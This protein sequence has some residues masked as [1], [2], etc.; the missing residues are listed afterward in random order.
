MSRGHA[1]RQHP[2]LLCQIHDGSSP[3]LHPDSISDPPPTRASKTPQHR[4]TS[5]SCSCVALLHTRL[6]ATRRH[7]FADSCGS[8]PATEPQHG[9][10]FCAST[11]QA[12]R[13][14]N[15]PASPTQAGAKPLSARRSTPLI[16]GQSRSTLPGSTARPPAQ[17]RRTLP[18]ATQPASASLRTPHHA[19]NPAGA[20]ENFFLKALTNNWPGKRGR[21]TPSEL[22]RADAPLTSKLGWFAGISHTHSAQP[23]AARRAP[24]A[25]AGAPMSVPDSCLPKSSGR[26]HKLR[27]SSPAAPVAA[28]LHTLFAAPGARFSINIGCSS[29]YTAATPHQKCPLLAAGFL[30]PVLTPERHGTGRTRLV[31]SR[32][33]PPKRSL[34]FKPPVPRLDFTLVIRSIVTC[35]FLQ[36][37]I[38]TIFRMQTWPAHTNSQLR[39]LHDV[40]EQPCAVSRQLHPQRFCLTQPSVLNRAA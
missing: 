25:A 38:R 18:P 16:H 14:N 22:R 23:L 21:H 39:Q 12:L 40:P 6:L 28:A 29:C 5:S 36:L 24:A 3:K 34:H 7:S 19:A 10:S 35:D 32:Q 11:C 33:A 31:G 2:T 30:E 4:H 1:H 37:P 26:R 20:R 27:I 15:P 17:N 13:Q 8:S 9:N